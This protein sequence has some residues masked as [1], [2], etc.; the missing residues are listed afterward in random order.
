MAALQPDL[1]DYRA[2]KVSFQFQLDQPITL[3]SI[4]KIVLFGVEVSTRPRASH[5]SATR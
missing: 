5:A 2:A 3:A 1:S 4:E